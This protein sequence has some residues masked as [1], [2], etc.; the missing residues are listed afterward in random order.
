MQT[1]S[2]IIPCYNEEEG[3]GNLKKRLDPVITKLKKIYKI[4]LILVNDGST[5]NTLKL[6][7]LVFKKEKYTKIITGKN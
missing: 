3:I 5:D 4:E 1:L 6:M 2:I 7:N